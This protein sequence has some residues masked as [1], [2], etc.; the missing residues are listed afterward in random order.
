MKEGSGGGH[1]QNWTDLTV[2]SVADW[3][4]EVRERKEELK[5]C[6]DLWLEYYLRENRERRMSGE[7]EGS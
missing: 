7:D 5:K 3:K 4:W 2:C 1:G 6:P